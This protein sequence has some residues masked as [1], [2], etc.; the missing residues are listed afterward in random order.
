MGIDAQYKDRIFE[1]F[2]RLNSDNEHNGTGIGLAYC[3]KIVELHGGK[4]WVESTPEIG[5]AFHFT[6]QIREP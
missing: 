3:K 5:S 2:K 6:Y 4:I 1:M